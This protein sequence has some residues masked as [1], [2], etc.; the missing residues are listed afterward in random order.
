VSETASRGFRV[1]FEGAEEAIEMVRK[2]RVGFKFPEG[3]WLGLLAEF[4]SISPRRLSST[5]TIGGMRRVLKVT[6]GF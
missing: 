2:L 4:L 5:R 3:C 1:E 6:F